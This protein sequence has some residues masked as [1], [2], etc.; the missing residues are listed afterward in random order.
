M[1]PWRSSPARS[2]SIC[3]PSGPTMP[4]SPTGSGAG[5]LRPPDLPVPASAGRRGAERRR[6]R[7]ARGG[8]LRRGP[9]GPLDGGPLRA[10][11]RLVEPP[12]GL[13][14]RLLPRPPRVRRRRRVRRPAR[15]PGA[16]RLGLPLGGGALAAELAHSPRDLLRLTSALQLWVTDG[17]VR[18][19]GI[20]GIAGPQ[21]GQHH[22]ARSRDGRDRGG[23]QR[24][25]Q[26]RRVRVRGRPPLGGP[27][28]EALGAGPDRRPLRP[29]GARD[30]LHP[31]A[32]ADP[33]RQRRRPRRGSLARPDGLLD[34]GRPPRPSSSSWRFAL[35]RGSAAQAGDGRPAARPRAPAPAAVPGPQAVLAV[36]RGAGR[37]HARLLRGEH[38]RA[39]PDGRRGPRPAALL[40]A[41]ARAGRW[42]HTGPVP[43]RRHPED[44]PPCAAHLRARRARR[45][46]AGRD[47]PG[48]L[49]RGPG[50]RRPRGVAHPRRLLARVGLGGQ[51][52]ARFAGRLAVG[53]QRL[54]PGA[55]PALREQRI[56]PARLVLAAPR[57][58]ADRDRG[59]VLAS[60]APVGRAAVRVP[61]RRRAGVHP[62]VEQPP[63]G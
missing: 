55:A 17:V 56:S 44:R 43:V 2:R 53:R 31:V 37:C 42:D 23:L 25:S 60:G 21:G 11:P 51:A 61:P 38:L 19:L 35:D 32:C 48:L 5:R 8:L 58:P 24:R 7:G 14:A 63:L 41:A 59:P 33:A 45:E 1:R 18:T 52:R 26:P 54:P 16:L 36:R 10:Q 15:G 12:R 28:P 40:P 13:R 9:C 62:G 34:P 49:A 50:V 27:G 20:L 39:R 6:R 46:R 4:T 3:G 47:L 29:A 57:R 22:R 30:E